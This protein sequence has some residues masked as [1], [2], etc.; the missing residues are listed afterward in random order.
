MMEEESKRGEEVEC[1]RFVLVLI[2]C[3]TRQEI[4]IALDWARLADSPERQ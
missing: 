1:L 4:L 3:S 2:K